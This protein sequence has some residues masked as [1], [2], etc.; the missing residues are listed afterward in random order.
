M[1]R[2]YKTFVVR[3]AA[4]SAAACSS[5]YAT[6]DAPGHKPIEQVPRPVSTSPYQVDLISERGT[7][8]ETYSR[9]GRFYVLGNS[10]ERY[11]IRVS[12]PTS[13]RIEAVISVDG[14]D[15]IDGEDADFKNKRGYVIPP[16]GNVVVDGF[17]TST[18]HVASFRFS[19]VADSYADR[20]GKG[21][22]VGVIGVAIFDEKEQPQMI[23]P[24]PEPHD[25]RGG[26]SSANDE[27]SAGEP[28]PPA[29][30]SGDG[31]RLTSKS[32]SAPSADSAETC[33]QPT[34][35]RP[36]LGTKW[37][38]SRYSA[39][40][41][42]RF[43]RNNASVPVAMAQLRYNDA[44]GLRA[45]GIRL[46]AEPDPHELHLRESADPFPGAHGFATPPPR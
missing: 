41:F 45:L 9:G 16:H 27:A 22:N 8:L 17:R 3:L 35:Q 46:S 14:L 37:G 6:R 18:S 1:S 38:E 13:R 15:V 44:D 33:C 43:V 4:L 5:M 20:K 21:R 30:H 25:Y 28:A 26:G 32:S 31:G 7:P 39:V 29:R 12:N 11:S 40:Q 23:L 42:T 19:S 36:G 24:Q 34:R 2:D 10:G